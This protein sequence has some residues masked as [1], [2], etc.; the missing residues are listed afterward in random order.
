V[1]GS[2]RGTMVNPMKLSDQVR[3]A[4]ADS[5][6]TQY[7]LSLESGLSKSILSRFLSGGKAVSSDTLDAISQV[8][9][10][11]TVAKGPTRA[12]QARQ[13]GR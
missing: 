6:L 5:G 3:K 10:I 1:L 4:V 2:E 13:E 7:R 8:L 9:R 12:V 11:S